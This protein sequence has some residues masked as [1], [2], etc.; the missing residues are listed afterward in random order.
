MLQEDKVLPKVQA[1][2]LDYTN[3]FSPDLAMEIVENT[4][5]NEYIIKLI[6]GKQ[7]PYRPIYALSLIELETL[8][9]HIKTHLKTGFI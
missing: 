7:P 2:Y 1:K 6:D 4:S 3:M 5:M 9:A 8:K